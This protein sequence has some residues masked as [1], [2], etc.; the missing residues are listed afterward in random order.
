MDKSD[1]RN[2][3]P[4]IVVARIASAANTA[5]EIAADVATPWTIYIGSHRCH[6]YVQRFGSWRW[7]KRE[8][9]PAFPTPPFGRRFVPH[10]LHVLGAAGGH[11]GTLRY[12]RACRARIDLISSIAT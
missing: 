12:K 8:P 2:E 11:R 6:R 9:M 10:D 3:T 5:N 4:L 7:L 1:R